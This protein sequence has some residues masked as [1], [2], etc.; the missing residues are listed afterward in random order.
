MEIFFLDSLIND[1]SKKVDCTGA[2]YSVLVRTGLEKSISV[3]M[4]CHGYLAEWLW[5]GS[6]YLY[7]W[8]KSYICR[9][10]IY[11]T[12]MELV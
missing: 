12:E 8:P 1:L 3:T 4:G 5:E 11:F 6:G 2:S 9:Q 7:K 10:S